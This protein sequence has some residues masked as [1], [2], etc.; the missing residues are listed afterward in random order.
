MASYLVML[1]VFIA[2][3]ISWRLFKRLLSYLVSTQYY[4]NYFASGINDCVVE[5][6]KSLRDYKLE[7]FD[8]LESSLKKVDGDILEIGAGT[9]ANFEFFPKGSSVIALD[10]SPAMRRH[11]EVNKEKFSHLCIKRFVEGRAEDMNE[12]PDCSVAAVV[13]TKVLCSIQDKRKAL[14][15]FKR[16]LRPVSIK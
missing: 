4:K 6:N 13:C 12:I 3:Y 5:Y 7:L 9:G 10:P 8:Q 14:L 15:E 1:A 16:V 2:V 11:F